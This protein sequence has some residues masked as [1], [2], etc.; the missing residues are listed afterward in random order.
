[1]QSGQHLVLYGILKQLD[2]PYQ[3]VKVMLET[4]PRNKI[5]LETRQSCHD[6]YVGE[7]YQLGNEASKLLWKFHLGAGN[8]QVY[9]DGSN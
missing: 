5:N 4:R 7:T 6:F 1:M 8:I 3:M 2:N 9:I